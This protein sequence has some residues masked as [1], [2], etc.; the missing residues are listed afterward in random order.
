[1]R[2][3]GLW[4]AEEDRHALHRGLRGRDLGDEGRD[5][6]THCQSEKCAERRGAQ[7]GTIRRTKREDERYRSRKQENEEKVAAR[8]LR[9][10]D[11]RG[12]GSTGEEPHWDNIQAPKEA[13]PQENEIR[14]SQRTSLPRK[15]QTALRKGLGGKT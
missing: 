1:M 11:R 13:Q 6:Q 9:W 4:E 15:I 5:Q 7:V 3:G 14:L 2:S 8:V 10:T 12:Q